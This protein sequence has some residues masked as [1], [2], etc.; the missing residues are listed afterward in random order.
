[1]SQIKTL[2]LGTSRLLAIVMLV[3]LCMEITSCTNSEQTWVAEARSPDGKFIATARTLQ[4]GGWGTGSPP[5][6]SVDLNWTTGS[7]KASEIFQFV[8][9][10]DQPENMKVEM[11]WLTPTHLEITYKPNRII[12]FQA[13]KC[14]N[15]D[16]TA[17]ELDTGTAH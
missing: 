16:I 3:G 1:M 15:V 4:P 17:R 12:Q 8:G 7:Q 5:E 6:T 11:V 2:G 14:F 9:D 10:A 13:V